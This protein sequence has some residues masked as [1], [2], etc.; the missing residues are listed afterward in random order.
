MSRDPIEDKYS[1]QMDLPAAISVLYGLDL[2]NNLYDEY[3]LLYGFE[4]NNTLQEI[5]IVGLLESSCDRC[6]PDITASLMGVVR[7][8][9]RDFVSWPKAERV[10]RCNALVGFTTAASAWDIEQLSPGQR[11][12]LD[13][14]YPDCPTRQCSQTVSVDGQCVYSSRANYV[15]WGTMC[16]L[17]GWSKSKCIRLANVWKRIAYWHGIDNDTKRWT[18]LGYNKWPDSGAIVPKKDPSLSHCAANCPSCGLSF[19]YKWS[20]GGRDDRRRRRRGSE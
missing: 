11:A 4:R 20:G 8:I 17:C 7:Q 3:H 1:T 5:D 13:Y 2:A 9:R 6:G 15:Q 12:T 16:D 10:K 14:I 18:E 19:T